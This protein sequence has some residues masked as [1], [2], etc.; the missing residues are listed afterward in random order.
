MP[1][2]AGRFMD[3]LIKGM[4]DGWTIKLLT[5]LAQHG[6]EVIPPVDCYLGMVGGLIC[7]FDKKR[8]NQ[9]HSK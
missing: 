9:R 5:S 1:L 3:G 4:F 7:L 2:S 6:W 8:S